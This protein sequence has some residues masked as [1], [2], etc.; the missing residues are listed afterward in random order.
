M[1]D[2]NENNKNNNN[3]ERQ[4]KQSS[5]NNNDVPLSKMDAMAPQMGEAALRYKN[6]YMELFN[7]VR[8]CLTG[9]M[10][11]ETIERAVQ[12]VMKEFAENPYNEL[13]LYSYATS[14][15]NYLSAHI[16]N[17]V[18]LSIGFAVSLGL[19]ERDVMDIGLC[20]FGHDFGMLEYV[21][22]FQ[23]TIKL[24]DQENSLIQQ[25]PKKSAEIFKPFFSDR[26]INGILDIHEQVNGSG[27][28]SRK[29]GAE[30]SFL[31]KAVA[32]CDAFEALT[33]PRKYRKAFSPY[34]AI[35][36]IIRQ[37]DII[38]DAKILTKFLDFISIYP[39]GSLVYLNTGETAMVVGANHGKPTK[40]V[41]RVLLNLKR[42]VDRSGK[43]VNLLEDQ[44]LYIRGCVEPK[45][46]GEILHFLKPRGDNEL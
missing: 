22:L 40:S 28:P 15:D 30:I 8:S 12:K 41:V 38:F 43:T 11:K 34:E 21:N 7:T 37:K 13:L 2:P 45:E 4:I 17:D 14:Q 23:K 36:M 6:T 19:P 33:H 46:E 16:T 18:I 35:K 9:K 29:L 31:G 3:V 26:V 42:E 5:L 1:A 32:L 25:H 10:N 24:T 20:A 39:V 44:M 27:Y